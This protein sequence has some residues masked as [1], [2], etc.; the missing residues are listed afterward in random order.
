MKIVCLSRGAWF[1]CFTRTE[2]TWVA[3]QLGNVTMLTQTE[4]Q[5]I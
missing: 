4:S 2:L 5:T 1:V 3:S